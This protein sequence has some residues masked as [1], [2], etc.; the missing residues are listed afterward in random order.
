MLFSKDQPFFFGFCFDAVPAAL[1]GG[2]PVLDAIFFCGNFGGKKCFEFFSDCGK[3]SLN[4]T[5]G[6][7]K[8]LVVCSRVFQSSHPLITRL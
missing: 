3:K 5:K 7:L 1:R 6:L 2:V 8:T 4:P